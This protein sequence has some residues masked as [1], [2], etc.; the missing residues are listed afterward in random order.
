MIAID[1]R[2]LGLQDFGREGNY[3]ERQ[4]SRWSRQYAASETE[5]IE[6]MDNL[7]NWLPKNIPPTDGNT[8]NTD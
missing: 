4:I 1:W 2:K 7:I 6:P 3:Y 5:K 8:V